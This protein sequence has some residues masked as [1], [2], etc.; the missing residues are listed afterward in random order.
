MFAWRTLKRQRLASCRPTTATWDAADDCPGVG[1]VTGPGSCRA[2]QLGV[3][4]ARR[5]GPEV[6][7]DL[8]DHRRVGD[9]GDEAHRAVAGLAH[10]RVDLEDLLQQRR[11][12]AAGL[13]G[14]YSRRRH[15]RY[16]IAVAAWS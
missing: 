7:E 12:P 8:V 14:R 11:P 1:H 15:D 13:G 4:L 9:E 10:E 5:A 3:C 2:P 6:G 16:V